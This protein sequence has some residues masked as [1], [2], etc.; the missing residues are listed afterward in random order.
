M[1]KAVLIRVAI[2]SHY[3]GDVG[4]IFEDG[5]FEYVPIPEDKHT[6]ETRMYYLTKGRSGHLLSDFVRKDHA[7]RLI[8]YDPEFETFTYGDANTRP[9]TDLEKG[10]YVVFYAGLRPYETDKHERGLYIIGYFVVDDIYKIESVLKDGGLRKILSNNAHTKSVRPE[11]DIII[12]KGNEESKLL[13]K[14]IL[15]SEFGAKKH[16]LASVKFTKIIGMHERY[17]QGY[18]LRR[19]SPRLVTGDYAKKLV[20]FIH[21]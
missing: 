18:D 20:R 14:A 11:T 17:P 3:G 1:M 8:H 16:W 13:K 5:S 10:D 19:S 4:P 12:I 15:I 2:D 9:L 7:E 21:Q 6:N